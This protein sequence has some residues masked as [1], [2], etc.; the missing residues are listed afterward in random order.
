MK[1]EVVSFIR[2]Y[3]SFECSIIPSTSIYD[4]WFLCTSILYFFNYNIFMNPPV[5]AINQRAMDSHL[6]NCY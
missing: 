2:S 6:E 4:I 3:H 1:I 5:S